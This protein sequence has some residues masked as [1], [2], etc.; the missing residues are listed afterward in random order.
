MVDNALPSVLSYSQDIADAKPPA[1][2]PAGTY[3][4]V[5]KG[6]PEVTLSK[7]SGKKMIVIPLFI[8]PDQYPA[9]YT[10]GNPDGTI[11]TH[12]VGAEDTPMGR[13]SVKR[14]CETFGVPMNGR[15]INVSEFAGREV[16]CKVT[17][18][19]YEGNPQARIERG[20]LSPV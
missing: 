20:G 7:S 13:Y 16:M 15:E 6:L 2:L 18:E 8:S 1:P 12:Y 17:H 4:A 9:D 5:V 3:R 19:M 10:D 14:A 11:L